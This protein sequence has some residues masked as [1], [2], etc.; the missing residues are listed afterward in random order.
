MYALFSLR[1]FLELTLKNEEMIAAVK[2]KIE[3]L[4]AD[5]K[6]FCHPW[7]TCLVESSHNHA[8]VFC[9]KRVH[10]Y[11]SFEGRTFCSYSK[12]NM[13]YGWI[14][15]LYIKLGMSFDYS[16]LLSY[17]LGITVTQDLKSYLRKKDNKRAY[18]RKRQQSHGYKAREK[19]LK[20][21]K[22]KEA[23]EKEK[24]SKKRKHTYKEK[25]KK[26]TTKSLKKRKV[27]VADLKEKDCVFHDFI[28]DGKKVWYRGDITH[29]IKAA[30]E[31]Y[32]YDV[33]FDDGEIGK[34]MARSI[35]Q[36]NEPPREDQWPGNKNLES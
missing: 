16:G 1:P 17:V 20:E 6:S 13:G 24:I 26:V 2:S 7:H 22:K 28:V 32:F 36:T 29:V 4:V 35:L 11:S 25:E 9:E 12:F 33:L 3:E 27:I 14:K 31:K 10:Y 18:H 19:H 30:D 23:A 5:A 21:I 34:R 15:K 8:L